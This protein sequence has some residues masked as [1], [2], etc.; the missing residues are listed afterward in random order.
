MTTEYDPNVTTHI[1]TE[2]HTQAFV[3]KATGLQRIKDIPWEIKTITWDTL[4][5]IV[6]QGYI[7]REIVDEIFPERLEDPFPGKGKSP[8]SAASG[9]KQRASVQRISDEGD[10]SDET[11]SVDE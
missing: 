5:R 2:L 8:L 7:E 6:N 1:V 11:N 9:S 3:L 4:I 10:T